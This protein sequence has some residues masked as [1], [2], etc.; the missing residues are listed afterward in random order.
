MALV[1]IPHLRS[2]LRWLGR[3]RLLTRRS[4]FPTGKGSVSSLSSPGSGGISQ[5]TGI[6]PVYGSAYE[7][8]LYAHR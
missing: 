5:G 3:P 1:I 7:R 2:I 4:A 6:S 8:N